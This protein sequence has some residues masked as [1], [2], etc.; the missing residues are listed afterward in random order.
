[1]FTVEY[2]LSKL[3]GHKRLVEASVSALIAIDTLKSCYVVSQLA[4]ERF[5]VW[6]T[7][8]YNGLCS[9]FLPIS[10]EGE[11]TESQKLEML[12]F[13]RFLSAGA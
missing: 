13:C 1:M 5:K 7:Q 9:V 10:W 12:T 11:D 3:A 4:K 2:F 6:N 8:R